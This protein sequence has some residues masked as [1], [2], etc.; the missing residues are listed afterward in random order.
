MN[1]QLA[2][3]ING[4]GVF[5]SSEITQV[6]DRMHL[7]PVERNA[8]LLELGQTCQAFHFIQ[9]GSFRHY[10]PEDGGD[11]TLNLW[12]EQ[13]WALD[14]QSFAAQKP[15]RN[16]IRAMEDSEV[17]ELSVYQLHH[18][19]ELSPAFFQLGKIMGSAIPDD[20]ILNVKLSPVD[21]YRALLGKNPKLLQRFALKHIASYLGITPET[22]SRVR[23]KMIEQIS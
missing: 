18:L 13:Q 20:E 8:I 23:K 19:I 15:S 21:K 5:T 22:L 11:T 1:E 16:I 14:Y 12:T 17:Y 4:F 6:L 9:S 2:A 3:A 7:F 10:C